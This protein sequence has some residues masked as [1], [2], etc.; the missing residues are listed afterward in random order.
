MEHEAMAPCSLSSGLTFPAMKDHRLKEVRP[1]TVLDCN[2]PPKQPMKKLFLLIYFLSLTIHENK[3]HT[4]SQ[5]NQ[6]SEIVTNK[7]FNL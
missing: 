1:S 5:S 4:P 2:N 7:K 3:W 6:I